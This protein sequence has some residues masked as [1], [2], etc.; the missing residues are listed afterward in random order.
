MTAQTPWSINAL[1][2]QT[3]HKSTVSFWSPSAQERE[4]LEPIS[5]LVEVEVGHQHGG[6]VAR[7]LD[8]HP[9]VGVGDEARSVE[10]STASSKPIRF[11][12]TMNVPFAI[13]LATITCCHSG[14][15]SNSGWS[16]SEPIAVG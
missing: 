8:Q 2:L 15:V 12:A 11:T 13:P 16:G 9:A 3:F 5:A 10:L 14:S 4:Q 7:R 6:L 1:I